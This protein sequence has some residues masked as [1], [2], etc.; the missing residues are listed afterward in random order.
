[1]PPRRDRATSLSCRA[2]LA[3]GAPRSGRLRSSVREFKLHAIDQVKEMLDVKLRLEWIWLGNQGKR[4]AILHPEF[5][6]TKC[7]EDRLANRR[8]YRRNR[9]VLTEGTEAPNPDDEQVSFDE[10]RVFQGDFRQAANRRSG[11]RR[12]TAGC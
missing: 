8:R 3:N 2:L 9:N 5:D 11:K 1:M 6:R 7:E 10:S 4:D 12:R